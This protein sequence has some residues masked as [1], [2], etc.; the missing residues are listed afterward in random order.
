MPQPPAFP[1]SPA[2]RPPSGGAFGAFRHR[3]FRFFWAGLVISNQGLWMQSVAQSWLIFQ[4]THSPLLVGLDG[5][6]KTAPFLIVSLYAGTVVDR[7]DRRKLLMWTEASVGSLAVVLAVL[8]WSERIELWHLY[9]NSFLV[10]SLGSFENPARSALLPH[11]VPRSDLMTALSLNS[12][13][14]KGSQMIGPA[15]GGLLVASCGVGWTFFVRGFTSAGLLYCLK[16]MRTTNP[17]HTGPSRSAL[18][19]L[20]EGF[21]YVASSPLLASLLVIQAMVSLFGQY[22]PMLVVF[23]ERVFNV[24]AQG[25]GFLQAAAGAGA[26]AGSVFLA[27]RGDVYHKGRLQLVGGAVYAASLVAFA[28][29]GS[30]WLAMVF[31]AV[32]GAADVMMG[33]INQT[34]LQLTTRNDMLGRVTSLS[35]M[36][37]R[38]LGPL[39]GFQAGALTTLMGVQPATAIG[40]VVCFLS[41]LG[42]A[43]F[44]PAIRTFAG[45][46]P[47]A[48]LEDGPVGASEEHVAASRKAG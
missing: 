48:A 5:V 31:L 33:A 7:V 44:L 39:G 46:G 14:R 45:A 6:F 12:N 19:S 2:P 3:D 13:V 16:T 24:G 41:V 38:G 28:W 36:T 47:R 23:S 26:V 17:P 1:A 8:V 34:M 4:M 20:Q 22:I 32:V 21:R 11:L 27:G 18:H 43:M 37:Q 25:L 30:F 29:S 9:L 40:A 42:A 10:S 15:I 35:A